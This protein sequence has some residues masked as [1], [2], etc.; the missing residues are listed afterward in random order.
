[1]KL[2]DLRDGS[3]FEVG[4]P[5]DRAT[6]V[7]MFATWDGQWRA[8]PRLRE[9]GKKNQPALR[10]VA[11]SI[12]DPPTEKERSAEILEYVK[13][14]GFDGPVAWE[15]AVIEHMAVPR[16]EP[17]FFLIDRRGV[18]RIIDGGYYPDIQ[19]ERESTMQ[20]VIDER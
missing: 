10:V 13:R 16:S 17:A 7:F 15:H 19:E 20:K 11:I 4:A 9:F 1:M 2:T 8:F 14:Y 12:D 6:L 3:S 5:S 18:T